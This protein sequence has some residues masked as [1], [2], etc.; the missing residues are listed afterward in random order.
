MLS[1][2]GNVAESPPPYLAS[3]PAPHRSVRGVEA[4]LQATCV[5]CGRSTG[6]GTRPTRPPFCQP[7]AATL[8]PTQAAA[9]RTA[10]AAGRSSV[11]PTGIALLPSHGAAPPAPRPGAWKRRRERGPGGPSPSLS[12]PGQGAGDGTGGKSGGRRGTPDPRHDGRA[13]GQWRG[14]AA[15]RRAARGR[16]SAAAARGGVWGGRRVWGAPEQ[17]AAAW[18]PSGGGRG[19]RAPGSAPPRGTAAGQGAHGGAGGE[20]RMAPLQ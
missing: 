18:P 15:P 9:P 12:A 17:R 10:A 3:P 5:G 11:P 7:A 19:G 13:S 6:G 2:K 4:V 1:S 14:S 20:R 16:H 8:R